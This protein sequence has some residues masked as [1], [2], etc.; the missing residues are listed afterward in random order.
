MLMTE[1]RL[2]AQAQELLSIIRAQG[3]EWVTRSHIADRLGKNRLNRWHV[4]LLADLDRYG[5]IETRQVDAPG[6]IGYEW[7]YRAKG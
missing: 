1:P 2:T 7:Q 3:G 4:K 5:L 6:P